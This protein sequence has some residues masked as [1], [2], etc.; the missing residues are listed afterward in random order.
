MSGKMFTALA[1]IFV[2]IGLGVIISL[3]TV[4]SMEGSM[5]FTALYDRCLIR[6]D[7]CK[8]SVDYM[9]EHGFMHIEVDER[10]PDNYKKK[11][12]DCPGTLF[13]CEPLDLEV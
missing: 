13:W 6:P 9:R 7:C 1:V 12:L 4:E 11:S 8:L 10:C 3:S 5:S 2:F